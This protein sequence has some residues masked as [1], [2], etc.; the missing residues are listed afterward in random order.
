MCFR[1][2][3]IDLLMHERLFSGIQF[4]KE[5]DE[6]FEFASLPDS[7]FMFLNHFLMRIGRAVVH[8]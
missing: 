5:E 4:V 6:V 3:I 8:K 2:G 1:T 7:I